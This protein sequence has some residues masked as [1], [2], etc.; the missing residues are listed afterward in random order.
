LATALLFAVASTA[1]GDEVMNPHHMVGAD[2]AL[3]DSVCSLCHEDDYT[4]TRSKTETCTLCHSDR[5]HVGAAEH[6]SANAA[7][8]KR[9]AA[10][11]EGIS[12]PLT[13]DDTLYCGSCHLYHDPAVA[14]EQWLD[15]G[16]VPSATEGLGKAVRDQLTAWFAAEEARRDPATAAATIK[17]MT[18]GTRMLRLPA[19]NGTLCKRCHG[20]GGLER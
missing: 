12:I 3:D 9:L 11:R 17:W 18:E 2:G 19:E 13:D 15:H 6:L 5:P 7:A 4:L 20:A 8:V 14:D 1:R 16:W 10:D